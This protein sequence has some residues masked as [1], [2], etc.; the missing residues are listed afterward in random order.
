MRD[1]TRAVRDELAAFRVET[2]DELLDLHAG[3]HELRMDLKSSIEVRLA[4]LE[5]AVFRPTGS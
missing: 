3:L 5:A 2:H 1:E 4:K